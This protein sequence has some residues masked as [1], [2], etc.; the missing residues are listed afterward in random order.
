VLI[1]NMYN[2]RY[3]GVPMGLLEFVE[4]LSPS[5]EKKGYNMGAIVHLPRKRAL[6]INI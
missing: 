6:Y 2:S 1:T 3:D 5:Y 4:L